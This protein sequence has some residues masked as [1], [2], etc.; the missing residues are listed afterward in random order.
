M[1]GGQPSCQLD[2][3][4]HSLVE[5]RVS[6]N[7]VA[8]RPNRRRLTNTAGF[9]GLRSQLEP[10]YSLLQSV[11][12]GRFNINEKL[13]QLIV[14]SGN[15]TLSQNQWILWNRSKRYLRS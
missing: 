7:D 8:R 12:N 13:K 2:R 3:R 14:K 15:Y 6:R 10:M 1:F 11:N 5:E 4:K 9:V